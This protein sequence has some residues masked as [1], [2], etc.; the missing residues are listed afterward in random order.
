MRQRIDFE[1]GRGCGL[2][3]KAV[4]KK[5]PANL[6]WTPNLEFQDRR[7]QGLAVTGSAHRSKISLLF[8]DFIIFL[9]QPPPLNPQQRT[10]RRAGKQQQHSASPRGSCLASCRKVSKL[11]SLW[12]AASPGAP[13][14]SPITFS[15]AYG[16]LGKITAVIS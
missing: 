13:D 8:E 12:I 2:A 16:C 6:M 14:I 5:T 15:P 4:K 7:S 1:G 10:S 11:A 9:M 3:G